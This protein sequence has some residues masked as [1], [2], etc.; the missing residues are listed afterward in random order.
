M[1]SA[2]QVAVGLT[3]PEFV[4]SFFLIDF[5]SIYFLLILTHAVNRKIKFKNIIGAGSWILTLLLMVRFVCVTP[6]YI[7]FCLILI[8]FQFNI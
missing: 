6:Q 1:F 2:A 3:G 8:L 5:Y 7:I 4:V